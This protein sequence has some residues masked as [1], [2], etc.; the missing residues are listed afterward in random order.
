MK[1]NLFRALMSF[2][3][4]LPVVLVMPLAVSA[5]A[6]AWAPGQVGSPTRAGDATSVSAL[7]AG[8]TEFVVSRAVHPPMLKAALEGGY[9]IV[10]Q[11]TSAARAAY[12]PAKIIALTFDDGP[13]RYTPQILSILKAKGVKATFFAIGRQVPA[14][15]SITRALAR[16][17]MSVQNHTWDHPNL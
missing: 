16:A 14:Y 1:P 2:A 7:S 10:A 5:P 3:A 13:G 6:P 9:S 11:R 12:Q 8:R 17:G 4:C 15:Q